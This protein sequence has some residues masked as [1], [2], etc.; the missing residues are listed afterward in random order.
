MTQKHVSEDPRDFLP[1]PLTEEIL[2]MS[3]EDIQREALDEGVDL[4]AL[5]AGIR[6][7]IAGLNV[8]TLSTPPIGNNVATLSLRPQADA[9]AA[10][11]A[12]S[13]PQDNSS[14]DF[15]M[16]AFDAETME[17]AILP[18]PRPMKFQLEVQTPGG[19]LRFYE[20]DDG[21]Y[22]ALPSGQIDATRLRL[23][24][25]NLSLIWVETLRVHRIDRL[26]DVRF[27][28]FMDNDATDATREA[29]SW[30]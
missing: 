11:R 25:E 10:S 29:V 20:G 19:P 21:F 17:E 6:A 12:G 8:S 27:A 9:D 2:A 23:G 18:I 16:A 15:L 28:D 30:S 22:V 13:Q 5:H 26:D 7:F 4:D 24:E 1:D 3:S 14:G